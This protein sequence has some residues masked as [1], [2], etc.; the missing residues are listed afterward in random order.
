MT[1]GFAMPTNRTPIHRARRHLSHEEEMSLE[2]GDVVGE[3]SPFESEEERRAAWERHRDYLMARC[4]DGSRPAAWWDF[5]GPQLGVRRPPRLEYDKA[6]LWEARLLTP[7]E[8]TMLEARW[9]KEF[10]HA[11]SPDY[12]GE[13]IGYDRERHCAI[14]AEGDKARKAHYRWAE[15]P[16]TLIKRWTKERKRRGRARGTLKVIADNRKPEPPQSSPPPA[17]AAPSVPPL[18]G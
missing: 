15:I 11:N 3:R 9:R 7:Q 1:G 6:T 8:V 14:W 2:L 16:H 10:D 17:P 4:D 5:D 18:I 13:C 12:V